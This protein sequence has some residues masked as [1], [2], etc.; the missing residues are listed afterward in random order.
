MHTGKID[1]NIATPL[2][3]RDDF[4]IARSVFLDAFAEL[5]VSVGRLLATSA[6]FKSSEKK[7]F[8]HRV[9]DLRDLKP[10]PKISKEKCA[11]IADKVARIHPLL[12]IRSDIVHSQTVIANI[13]G[14]IHAKICNNLMSL[15]AR[16]YVRLLRIEDFKAYTGEARKIANELAQL[17]N[18]PSSPPRPKPAAT[19]GL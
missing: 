12:S 3:N 9:Q 14:I 17:L 13:D 1:V 11:K 2:A 7:S 18:P 4:H 16:P 5:E 8:G 15:E 10:C 6:T 19:G